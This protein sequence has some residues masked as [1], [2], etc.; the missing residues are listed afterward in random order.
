MKQKPNRLFSRAAMV[1]LMM[2]LTA[3]TAWAEEVMAVYAVTCNTTTKKNTLT[4]NGGN[5]ESVTWDYMSGTNSTPWNGGATHGVD[6]EY[7]ITFMPNKYLTLVGSDIK[8]SAETKFTVTVGDNAYYIKS[9]SIGGVTAN[10]GLN[11]KSLDVTVPSGSTIN[12]LYVTLIRYYT[13]TP[14]SGLTVTS[15]TSATSGGTTYYKPGTIVTVAPTNT[16]HIVEGTGGTGSASVSVA[17]DKR[18]FSFT[19]PDQDVSP[20]ATLTEVYRVSPASGITLSPAA[21]F[22]YGGAQYYKPNTTITLSSTVP[23]GQHVIYKAGNKTLAGN[24][25]TVNSSDGDVTLT[26]EYPY[27][28]YTVQFNGNGSTSGSMSNQS[29]TYA[30]AQNLTDNGYSRTITVTYNYNGATGGNNDATAIVTSTFD[31][32]ATSVDGA[33]VYDNQQSVPCQMHQALIVLD[34]SRVD[35]RC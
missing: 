8:T 23:T 5:R 19:M 11:A 33:K 2:L 15:G 24:T 28:T 25:Y 26:A 20:T 18:S 13:V 35:A 27:N 12:V 6:D 32:W 17:S 10:A 3:T 4:H 9:A 22:T 1:L 14:A 29:F 21:Y 16:H 7:G 30:T 34:I 31:G